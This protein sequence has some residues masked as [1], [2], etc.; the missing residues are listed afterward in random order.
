MARPRRTL[1]VLGG[2]SDQLFLIRTA[3]QMGLAVLCLDRD[4]EAPGL[5]EADEAA[6]VSTR[7]VPAILEFLE[8]RLADG[9]SLHGVLTMGSDVPAVVAA[10]AEAFELPGPTRACA[11][12]ATDKL[13]MKQRLRECGIP[14]PWFAEVRG[15]GELNAYLRERGRLVLEPID[16]SG[17]RGVFVLDGTCDAARLL[18]EAREQSFVGRVMVEE[19]L[20]G[21][22]VSTECVLWDERAATP[23]FADRNHELLERFLPRVMENGGQVPSRL[24]G[25]ERAATEDVTVAAARAL[26]IARGTA[27][28]AV[29]WTPAGPVVI[30][31]AARLSGGDFCESLVPLSTGVNLVRAAVRI[32]LGEEPD[33]RE[34]E[35]T[36]PERWVANRYLF[37]TPGRL[38]AVE[39]AEK[40]RAQPWVKKLE[41]AYRP[42]D[43]VPPATSHASRF[44]VFV[45]VADD[46]EALARRVEWVY[47]T[48]RLETRSDA[49]L[50][51]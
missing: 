15:L 50:A 22:R 5:Q 47:R 51:A 17:S 7:D 9:E 27:R 40:V 25:A 2:S 32:A 3:Q 46:A 33:W 16:R 8:E 24:A 30:E 10:V 1:L 35:P 18:R 4:P 44:G 20:E 38:I 34:L 31:V 43:L 6:A 13:A 36:R 26:G 48:L 42:G 37:P 19:Y 49:A 39:G 12:L 21:P 41:L 11:R 14:I 28:G 23:G 29:V 45:V